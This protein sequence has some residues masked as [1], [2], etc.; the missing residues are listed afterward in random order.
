VGIGNNLS[1]HFAASR[2]HLPVLVLR[3]GFTV[4]QAAAI[5]MN[6]TSGGKSVGR[7]DLGVKY[8]KFEHFE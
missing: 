8:E 4:V 5:D 6:G 2:K 7:Y 3:P 1:Q